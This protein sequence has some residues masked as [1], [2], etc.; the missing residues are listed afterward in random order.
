[1]REN[2]Q[3]KEN[4]ITE[5]DIDMEFGLFQEGTYPDA[6]PDQDK[7]AAVEHALP[8]EEEREEQD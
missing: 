4:L 1:M 6:L 5:R 3:Q 7:R 2:N 8:K